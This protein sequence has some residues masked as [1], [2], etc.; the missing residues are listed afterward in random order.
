MATLTR[1]PLKIEGRKRHQE[2]DWWLFLLK[3]GHHTSSL[4]LGCK[5]HG[6]ASDWL[7]LFHSQI[8]SALPS[9]GAGGRESRGSLTSF[10]LDALLWASLYLLFAY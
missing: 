7:S 10:M 9:T 5:T 4:V 8:P 2:K 6:H 3:E 1:W